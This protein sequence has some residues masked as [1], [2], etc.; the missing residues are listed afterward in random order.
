MG[1]WR[2]PP[3]LELA[4]LSAMQAYVER[5]NV[6]LE[7]KMLEV[8][9]LQLAESNINKRSQNSSE[10]EVFSKDRAEWLH[11]SVLFEKSVWS[12]G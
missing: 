7:S 3:G 8:L 12:I 9:T 10:K 2:Y 1:A 11:Q 6:A 4:A 5:T